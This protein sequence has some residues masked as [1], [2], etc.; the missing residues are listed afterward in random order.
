MN[1]PIIGVA[2]VSSQNLST[3]ILALSL[4]EHATTFGKD[5]LIID[6]AASIRSRVLFISSMYTPSFALAMNC[7]MYF[8]F[9]LVPIL[10]P[11]ESISLSIFS[12]MLMHYALAVY[13]FKLGLFNLFM[14]KAKQQQQQSIYQSI[15]QTKSTSLLCLSNYCRVVIPST[16]SS[17]SSLISSFIFATLSPPT[18]PALIILEPVA[19]A[20]CAI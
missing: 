4:V 20:T 19:T 1:L 7:S 12:I 6:A 2:P 14:I 8:V 3:A 15:I 16:I 10:I 17:S 9:T 13:N 18:T 5:L 11:A